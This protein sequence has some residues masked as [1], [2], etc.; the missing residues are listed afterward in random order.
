MWVGLGNLLTEGHGDKLEEVQLKDGKIISTYIYE[1]GVNEQLTD[2]NNVQDLMIK[3][4]NE[5]CSEGGLCTASL[6]S[7]TECK[8][9]QFSGGGDIQMDLNDQKALLTLGGSSGEVVLEDE[10]SPIYCDQVRAGPKIEL[11]HKPRDDP[12]HIQL[13]LRANMNLC[14]SRKLVK[15]L[16]QYSLEKLRTMTIY[17][18]TFG[19]RSNHLLLKL[20]IDFQTRHTFTSVRYTS[21]N[22]VPWA[23]EATVAYMLSK[24]QAKSVDSITPAPSTTAT[25]ST[26]PTPDS[27]LPL[28]AIA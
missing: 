22:S 21:V 14:L 16:D 4:L 10:Q 19:Y 27:T 28:P 3:H 11:K 20:T 8:M 24:M 1:H 6:T 26:T 2:E 15:I 5:N 17:G 9:S 18:A 13:Q 23:V 12:S 25:P 7:R